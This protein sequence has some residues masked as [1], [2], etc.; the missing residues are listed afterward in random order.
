MYQLA[1]FIS[2]VLSPLTTAPLFFIVLA[3]HYTADPLIFFKLNLL[4]FGLI[5]VPSVGTLIF[6]KKTQRITDWGMSKREERYVFNFVILACGLVAITTLYL[7]GFYDISRVLTLILV[8][9]LLFT[10]ITFYTKISAHTAWMS[11]FAILTH[12]LYGPTF[13]WVWLLVPLVAWARVYKKRHTISQVIAGILLPIVIFALA[14]S[15]GF[16]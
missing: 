9:G 10:L 13:V 7:L 11:L 14:A 2:I 15:I 5:F 4:L 8:C 3:R 1:H 16:V 6:L 12:V